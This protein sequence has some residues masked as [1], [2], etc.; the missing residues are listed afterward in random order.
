MAQHDYI[1]ANQSGAGFR[2]DL[3]NALAAIVSQN[4]G[5]S[6]PS[7]TYAYQ[8]WADTTAGLLKQRNAANNAW[9]TIGTLGT[10]N[11]GL[12]SASG[13]T[14]TGDITLNAQSD[15][16][17]ADSDS[18]NW[19][20]LQA[21]GTVSSNVTWT[22]P[23]ADGTDGQKLSTN[24]SG[25]L[26]WTASVPT[27]TY[28]TSGTSATYTPT[29]GTKAIYVEVVG[30]G[31]GGGGVDGQGAGTAALAGA[32]GGGAYVA[33]MIT[34]MSQTFTYTIGAGGSA[35]AAG[36]NNGGTGGTTTFIASVTGTLTA[37]GG[38]GGT[39][40]LAG[41]S[42][43]SGGGGSGGSTF[44]GGDLNL[45]GGTNTV[46]STTGTGFGTFS[47]AGCAPY[48][49]TVGIG[50]RASNNNGANGS[51]PGEGGAGGSVSASTSNFAGGDG[52]AGAIRIT[53]YF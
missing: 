38:T 6:E 30:A 44:T 19:V 9:V 26:S 53:E 15:L 2:S 4:S 42:T 20:A 36:V 17:F 47:Q 41:S 40:V 16:R 29:T 51:N 1:I 27:I 39:G 49:G 43:D 46:A 5:A 11:L 13:G 48:F 37:S 35:G 8:F 28:I 12:L 31:G 18:S 33:K 7:T 24:G 14:I 23:A 45:R 21:P 25:T 22:L 32:G 10:V 52:A 34:D 3:N 50:N